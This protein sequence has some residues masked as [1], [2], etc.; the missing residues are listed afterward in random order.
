MLAHKKTSDSDAMAEEAMH[1]ALR[2]KF[3][4]LDKA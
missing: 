3:M 4:M 2:I 1:S